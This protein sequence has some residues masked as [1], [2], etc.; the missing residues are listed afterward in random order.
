MYPGVRVFCYS[1][2]AWLMTPE[3]A[4]FSERFVTSIVVNKDLFARYDSVVFQCFP[5]SLNSP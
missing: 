1:P 3:L 4:K 5:H 2:P